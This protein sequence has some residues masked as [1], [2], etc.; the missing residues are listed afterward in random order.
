M[1]ITFEAFGRTFRSASTAAYIL[2]AGPRDHV[3][4]FDGK[5]YHYDPFVIGYAQSGRTAR[6]RYFSESRKDR[7]GGGI[8][9]FSLGTGR[10]VA[11]GSLF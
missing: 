9:I 10:E 11:V 1:S 6:K 4:Q 3:S 5:T 2:V 7:A 8:K